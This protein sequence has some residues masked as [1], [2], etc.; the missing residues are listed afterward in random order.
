MNIKLFAII[1]A[2][3][4]M[5]LAGVNPENGGFFVS[6]QDIGQKT[7]GH[8]LNLKRTYNSRSAELGWFGHGWG[9]YF[10]TRLVILPDS[11]AVVRE[12]GSGKITY[13]RN[14]NSDVRGA[15]QRIADAAQQKDSLSTE[16]REELVKKLRASEEFRM[17]QVIMYEVPTQ[18][19]IGTKLRANDCPEA[20]LLREAE[21][22]KRITC[23]GKKEYFDSKGRLVGSVQGDYAVQV[24]YEGIRPTALRDTSGQSIEMTWT[25]SGL[26]TSARSSN[27]KSSGYEYNDRNQLVATT[28]MFDNRYRYE[29]DVLHNLTRIVFIDTTSIVL[30]YQRPNSGSVTSMTERNGDQTQYEYRRDPQDMGLSWTKITSIPKSGKTTVREYEFRRQISA[31]GVESLQKVVDS[32]D[33]R[34][35]EKEYDSKGRVVRR[36]NQN[37]G[38]TE[39]VY[40]PKNDK[41]ILIHSGRDYTQFHYDESGNMVRAENSEGLTVELFYDKR[42]NVERIVESKLT[43]KLRRTLLLQYN[44][45]GKPVKITLVGVG[46]IDVD[47]DSDGEVVKVASKQGARVS[48]QVAEVFQSLLTVVKVAGVK[49]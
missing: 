28:D 45:I 13:Y 27:G 33:F 23:D 16:D 37:G 7:G 29:Y 10:E 18:L 49:M 19:Q 41:L 46:R 6:Y 42:K 40:H 31:D 35:I 20:E 12:N 17:R 30:Q 44:A 43:A 34:R 2:L 24:V 3:P 22:Y 5:A 21:A 11:S 38:I 9:S 15:V 4:V 26:L 48:Q 32:N 1:C 36:G 47:Y 25:S 14:P 8:E 39:F